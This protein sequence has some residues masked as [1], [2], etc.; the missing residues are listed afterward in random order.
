MKSRMGRGALR[1]EKK[2]Q[3]GNVCREE[4]NGKMENKVVGAFFLL[5]RIFNDGN[6]EEET[7][8]GRNCERTKRERYKEQD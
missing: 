1:F 2:L 8:G 5:N 7:N 4:I 6:A 3:I